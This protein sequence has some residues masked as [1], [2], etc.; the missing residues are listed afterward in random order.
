MNKRSIIRSLISENEAIFNEEIDKAS[1]AINKRQFRTAAAI[2]QSAARFAW[3]NH[4]GFFRSRRLEALTAKLGEQL[5]SHRAQD[6]ES[7]SEVLH[8]LTQAYSTGGHTRLVWRWIDNDPTRVHSAVLTGQ[9]GEPIPWELRKSVERSG[10]TITRI[11]KYNSNLMAR[12][13]E[14][15][16]IALR[17]SGTIVLHIHP[18]DVVPIIALASV[19]VKVIF[20]NHADHVFWVGMSITTVLA[21]IRPAGEALSLAARQVENTDAAMLPIPLQSQQVGDRSGAR[22]SLGIAD[23]AVLIITIASSYKYAVQ[24]ERHFVDVH[25]NFVESN[26][27]VVLIA[28]GPNATGRWLE[29]HDRT[30]G[31]F[32]AVGTVQNLDRY[33]D[34]ADIYVDSIPFSSLTSLVDAAARGLPVLSL[35]ETVPNSVLTSD[36]VSLIANSVHFGVRENYLAE[37]SALTI[38]REY[39]REVSE[40]LQDRVSL[41]HLSPG[42]NNHLERLY[43]RVDF[44]T[45]GHIPIS[46]APAGIKSNSFDELELALLDFQVAS[47]LA[48]PFWKCSIREAP[49]LPVSGRLDSFMSL[50][51]TERAKHLNFMLPE[52]LRTHISIGWRYIRARLI[53]KP[54]SPKPR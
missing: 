2:L 6:P 35:N 43:E 45:A 31:R 37:L 21:N 16:R 53:S 39:R 18:C 13:A 14:L 40:E 44:K 12:A 11:G 9:Q 50:P 47:G 10:G 20:L 33:Y 4:P 54:R 34:A 19:P 38:T 8:I 30:A 46:P 51:S 1:R 52:A 26:E 24:N 29:A 28:I 49:F 23:D 22:A 48:G 17:H 41:D 5:P 42:W 7:G 36:D 32:S 15:R 27:N 3:F 25:L